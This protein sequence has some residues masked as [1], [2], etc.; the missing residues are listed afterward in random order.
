M[1]CNECSDTTRCVQGTMRY[2][3]SENMEYE[4]KPVVQVD[5]KGE[6]LKCAKEYGASD[7]GFKAGA[8]VCG[9]CGAMATAVKMVP[10]DEEVDE[11]TDMEEKDEKRHRTRKPDKPEM[12]P[13][14]EGGPPAAAVPEEEDAPPGPPPAPE[15]PGPAPEGP[16]PAPEGPAPAPE[17][18]PAPP[19]PPPP[20]PPE[21]GPPEEA[22]GEGPP[23]MPMRRRRPPPPPPEDEEQKDE[24][25]AVE[26]EKIRIEEEGDEVYDEDGNPIGNSKELADDEWTEE[27]EKTYADYR[28]RR[29]KNMG[30]KSDEY[31]DKAYVCAIERK[32]YPGASPVCDDCPGGCMA[33]KGMPGLLEIEGMVEHEFDSQIIDSGYSQ[34]ADMFV[35]DLATKDARAIEVFVDG[36]SAEVLGF[37][38]LDDSV[39]QH[40]T[41]EGDAVEY[42]SY[43]AAADIATKAV[44]GE[45]AS[46][47]PDVFEGFDCFAVEI[48]SVD[49][50]SYDVFIS[51]DGEML[52]HDI[53]E[54]DEVADIEAEAAEIALKRAFSEERRDEMAGSGQALPD[55]SYPIESE[56][57]LKNA[58]Q[59]YGRA[60]NKEAAKRHIMKRAKA[61]G[62]TKLIPGNWVAGGEKTI[63]LEDADFMESLIEFQLMSSEDAEDSE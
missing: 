18:A 59:A 13:A 1:P 16:G 63:Q 35:L 6:L 4:E 21:E 62:L 26:D 33:E 52:G 58:I 8:K 47:E 53:Y 40:K 49:G 51:L 31:G 60:K 7:C 14:E 3:E 38:R 54:T 32:V 37:H 28:K 25:N 15:G 11:E 12:P 17:E 19:P 45:V 5:D 55:G 50:K 34:D 39:L 20:P 57:D 56:T 22:P 23:P 41:L 36:S 42:I 27:D 30:A 10:L 29:L 48:D 61:L 24:K 46:V 43:S 2:K 9:K 44:P